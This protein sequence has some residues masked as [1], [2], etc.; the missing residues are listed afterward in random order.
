MKHFAFAFLITFCYPAQ[1]L[2]AQFKD[3]IERDSLML[4]VNN[5]QVSA[6]DKIEPFTRL[7]RQ[8][9]A[10]GD[11]ARSAGF[12]LEAKELAAD[13]QDM[14]CK[15]QILCSDFMFN[16]H[17]M[18][19]YQVAFE[20][21]KALQKA[22]ESASDL[23]TR[24]IAYS[25]LQF[26]KSAAN[27]ADTE[28][29]NDCYT[30]ISLA[31][32]LP[33]S[34]SKR[35]AILINCYRT[36][37]NKSMSD[38]SFSFMYAQKIIE[39]AQ[40]SGDFDQLSFGWTHVAACYIDRV[41]LETN[42]ILAD[43]AFAA[44]EEAEK[45]VSRYPDRISSDSFNSFYALKIYLLTQTNQNMEIR[46]EVAEKV[47]AFAQNN[48]G[49][50]SDKTLI[51]MYLTIEDYDMAEKY[52]SDYIDRQNK[53]TGA[54]K[55]WG[56]E[57]LALI[58]REKGNMQKSADYF[59]QTLVAYMKE[60]NVANTERIRQIEA[61]Y[62]NE[63][64]E[65]QLMF[66]RNRNRLVTFG[67]TII[68][69]LMIILFLFYRKQSHA[70]E[71][72]LKLQAHLKHLEAEK[73]QNQAVTANLHLEYQQKILSEA[74]QQIKESKLT[75]QEI[76]QIFR[77]EKHTDKEFS[78][79]KQFLSEISPQLVRALNQKANPD[80]LTNSEIRLASC[81]RM[82]MDNKQI[83]DFL[84][85]SQDYVRIKKTRLKNKLHLRKEDKLEHFIN[86]L[87]ETPVIIE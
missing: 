43:S 70:K 32:R 47:K 84:S 30:C 13:H 26:A 64:K 29:L 7:A 41:E 59:E 66:V 78:D 35:A 68:I 65:Q 20:D 74:K 21:V 71:N 12:L 4:L 77:K 11:S 5:P 76:E 38:V 58:Y 6:E 45:I 67:A 40:A 83:A 16:F 51:N 39:E 62:E 1:S 63:K 33:Q 28:V 75:N 82:N 86:R 44:I 24:A 54:H 9:A 19:N 36:L 25:F 31:E 73:A 46:R 61:Q 8:Y 17:I 14:R 50:V 81:I 27:Y 10:T 56:L 60:A 37:I 69:V 34:G 18:K 3:R 22:A 2:Q 15:I 55:S 79:F 42:P 23:E 57:L 72:T 87:S 48:P 49:T 80:K 85:I 52:L 53:L